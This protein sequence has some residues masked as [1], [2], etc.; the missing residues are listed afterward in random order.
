MLRVGPF[1]VIGPHP[2]G[3][4]RAVD[5]NR[6]VR[7]EVAEHVI[8]W[9]ARAMQ[10]VHAGTLVAK[11]QHPGIARIVD[12]GVLP[13]AIDPKPWVA[14]ELADGVA[15]SEIMARRTLSVDEVVEL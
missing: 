2:G 6:R 14:Y 12:R 9:R 5:G 15:L 8:D 1:R 13:D 7:I 10:L 11:F 3:G 4:Y